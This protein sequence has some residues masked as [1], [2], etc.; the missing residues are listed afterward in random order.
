MAGSYNHVT[1]DDSSLAPNAYIRER[2][3]T[4]GDAIET[5]EELYGM[6]W[7]LASVGKYHAKLG[8]ASPVEIVE[9]ARE[10]FKLGLEASPTARFCDQGSD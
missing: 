9:D 10:N 3:D 2:L 8:S 1:D 5:I 4:M 7:Y 6:I